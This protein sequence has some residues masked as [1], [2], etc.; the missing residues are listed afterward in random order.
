M[1]VINQI[2]LRISF[3]PINEQIEWIYKKTEME[4]K[5]MDTTLYVD[6]TLLGFVASSE[7]PVSPL[8]LSNYPQNPAEP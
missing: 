7:V 5:N 8:F 1:H 4:R 3:L 6:I 2:R